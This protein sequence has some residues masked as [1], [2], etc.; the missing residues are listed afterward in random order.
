MRFRVLFFLLACSLLLTAQ[1]DTTH[2]VIS[3]MRDYDQRI[4][5]LEGSFYNLLVFNW[6]ANAFLGILS[7]YV[8]CSES[9]IWDSILLKIKNSKFR[10]WR[11]KMPRP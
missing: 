8:L 2:N 3:V 1:T 9:G 5:I 7:L 6:I 10:L 11:D 4:E